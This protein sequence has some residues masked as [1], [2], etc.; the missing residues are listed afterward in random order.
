MHEASSSGLVGDACTQKQ[1]ELVSEN[2][3]GLTQA[4]SAKQA[5]TDLVSLCADASIEKYKSEFGDVLLQG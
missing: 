2:I 4:E 1:P 5:A 3:M